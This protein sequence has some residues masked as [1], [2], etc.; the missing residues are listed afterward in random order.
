[1]FVRLC[2]EVSFA[3]GGARIVIAD[4]ILMVLG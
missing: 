3:E 1:M 2:K 4:A